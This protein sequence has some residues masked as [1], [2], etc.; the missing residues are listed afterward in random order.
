MKRLG[1]MLL[2]LVAPLVVVTTPLVMAQ[3]TV[4]SPSAGKAGGPTALATFAGGCFWCTEADLDKVDGVLSTTSGYIGGKA[5]KPSY[6]QVS[7]GGTG[8]TEAVQVVYDPTRVSYEKLVEYFWR[9]IDPT[10][11]D[12]QFCDAGIAVPP[13]HLHARRRSAPH[14]VGVERSA[15][16][17]EAFRRARSSPRSRRPRRSTRPRTTT[18]TTTSATRCATPTTATDAGAI[19]GSRSCG[20][21]RRRRGTPMHAEHIAR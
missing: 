5:S 2:A 10:V 19:S 15:G 14:C 3:T 1:M 4:P 20:G 6:E 11:K 18:R 9:T 21:A 13:R 12:R 16:K 8:H 7:A 17:V